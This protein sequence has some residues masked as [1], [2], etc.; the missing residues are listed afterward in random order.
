MQTR[1]V[2]QPSMQR[3]D[4]ATQAIVS[5]RWRFVAFMFTLLTATACS[6]AP[7]AP[8]ERIDQIDVERLMP[9]VNDAVTRL[10]PQIDN[11]GIRERVRY[12]LDQLHIALVDADARKVRFHTVVIADVLREYI[13]GPGGIAED[14]PDVD[15]IRLMLRAV[16]QVV[17]AGVQVGNSSGV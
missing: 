12:D 17:H 15:A 6:D 2:F 13:G 14:S 8:N 10:S 4:S 16:S 1:R 7:L 3:K 9:S 5:A 11:G